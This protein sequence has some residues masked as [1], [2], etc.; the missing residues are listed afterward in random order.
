MLEEHVKEI[1]SGALGLDRL[2]G[3]LDSLLSKISLSGL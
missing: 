1:M 3:R 2:F